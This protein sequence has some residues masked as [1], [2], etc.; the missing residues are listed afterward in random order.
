V[1]DSQAAKVQAQFGASAAAYV[2]CTGFARGDDLEQ[3]VAWGATARPARVL[4][5]ATGGGHTALAFARVARA[6]TAVDL[7]EPMLRAAA[8]HVRE[9][10]ATNVGFVAA[11]AERLPFRERTFDVVSCRIAPHHFS[12]AAGAV[13]QIARVLKPGGVFVLEDI[14]GHDDPDAAAFITEVERRRDPSH[15]R[16]YRAA[17]WTASL[18]A[19]GLAVTDRLVI[20]RVRVWD[21]WTGM[22]RMAPAAKASLERFVREAPAAWRAPFDFKLS[23]GA[24]ESFSDRLIL[25]RATKA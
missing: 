24:V 6:V 13:R 17:E 4:D 10:G 25:L 3:L 22:G 20:R 16:A 18:Q 12:D 19:A 8:R 5:V 2:A 23:S 14:L 9:R 11:E 21:E 7:T 1:S 15:L